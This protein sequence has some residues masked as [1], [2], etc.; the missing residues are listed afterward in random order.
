MLARGVGAGERHGWRVPTGGHLR[1]VPG[2]AAWRSGPDGRN[3][4][5][6]GKIRTGRDRRRDDLRAAS[7]PRAR[8][9][10]HSAAAGPSDGRRPRRTARPGA[11]RVSPSARPP[12][13]CPEGAFAPR[14]RIPVRS[15]QT[16]RP[17]TLLPVSEGSR[18]ARVLSRSRIA[19]TGPGPGDGPH[20]SI[21]LRRTTTMGGD[22]RR[23][24]RCRSGTCAIPTDAP[25]GRRW[26]VLRRRSSAAPGTCTTL[27][28]DAPHGSRPAPLRPPAVRRPPARGTSGRAVSRERLEARAP[29]RIPPV[30][31][32]VPATGGTGPVCHVRNSWSPARCPC[33]SPRVPPVRRECGHRG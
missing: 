11:R 31:D 6:P 30:V 9:K 10:R 16:A 5:H 7:S 18:L 1:P 21:P 4:P 3:A 12:W 24:I 27:H 13:A 14:P 26:R 25:A 8:E 20:A 15:H 2:R 23:G 22:R 33:R 17:V 28:H 19:G 32:P 29:A